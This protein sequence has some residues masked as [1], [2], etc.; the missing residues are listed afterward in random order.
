MPVH[1]RLMRR[2]RRK[3][4]R[5]GLSDA[6]ILGEMALYATAK[7]E[8]CGGKCLCGKEGLKGWVH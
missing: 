5:P 3:A 4:S 7:D 8:E 1:E 6:E 2:L